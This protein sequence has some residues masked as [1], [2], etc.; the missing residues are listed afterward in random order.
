[1]ILEQQVDRLLA[2]QL[3]PV[4]RRERRLSLLTGWALIGGGA[5]AV[6]ILLRFLEQARAWDARM[7]WLGLC[8]VTAAAGWWWRRRIYGQRDDLTLARRAARL[9]E[10]AD[11]ELRALLLTA[12]AQAPAGPDG[13]LGYLQEELVRQALGKVDAV[14][15]Q[16]AIPKRRLYLRGGAAAAG[17]V[18]LLLCAAGA[19]A[20]ELPT[21]FGDPHGLEVSPGHAEGEQGTN[22][23]VLAR[24]HRRLPAGAML[25][26]RP[27]GKP[28]VRLDMRRTLDDPVWG[29]LT[30]ALAGSRMEYFVEYEGRRSPRYRIA[31]FRAPEVERLDAKVEYPRQ[32]NLPAK[33]VT[34]TRHLSVLEGA[35]VTIT[36]RLATRVEEVRLV[37]VLPGTTD[38]SSNPGE[39]TRLAAASGSGETI[40]WGVVQPADTRRYEVQV[41]DRDGRRNQAPPRLTI[42]VHRNQPA[43]IKLA[44]PGKDVRVSPLEELALEA[45]VEDDVAVLGQGISYRLAG[46]PS[47]E[48]R[49]DAARPGPISLARTSVFLEDLGAKPDQL[50]TYHFWAEDRDGHGK[51]RRAASDMYFAEVRPFEERFREMSSAGGEGEQE[52]GGGPLADQ[53]EKQKQIINATW[54]LERDARDGRP[55][56][57]VGKDA[58]VVAVSQQ[59]LRRE[60][61]EL[62]NKVNDPRVKAGLESAS[63]AMGEAHRELQQAERSESAG[64]VAALG[65]ALE[66]AQRAYASLLR[67]RDRERQVTRGKRGGGEG[68]GE[69]SPELSGLELK[70]KDS[71]YETRKEA[72]A[73]AARPRP[74]RE[75]L[76]RLEELAR[77]QKALSSRLQEAEQSLAR[78]DPAERERRLKSLREEQKELAEELEQLARKLEAAGQNQAARR[79][80]AELEGIAKEA[81][82][83][84]EALARGET[85]KALGA[86]TRA[87]RELERMRKDLAKEVAAGFEDEMRELRDA[88]SKLDQAQQAIGQSLQ[89]NTGAGGVAESPTETRRLAQAARAQKADAEQLL[90]RLQKVSD[91]AEAT[92]PLLSRKLY[93]GLREA[94]LSDIERALDSTAELLER[95]LGEEA[96]ASEERAR[97]GVG[98]LRAQVDD[99]A[100]GVL[101]DPEKALRQ[102][103]AEIDG[104]L[105]EAARQRTEGGPEK[106]QAPGEGQ[107]PGKGQ[108][109]DQGQRQ[110]QGQGQTPGQGQGQG[111]GQGGTTTERWA[112][113]GGRGSA[114]RRSGG[115]G[116]ARRLPA[117]RPAGAARKAPSPAAA[118]AAS[119][120][121]C[122]TSRICWTI[123]AS[124]RAPPRCATAPGPCAQSS[125]ITA[126]VPP[127]PCWRS[128]SGPADRAAPPPG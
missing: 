32:P 93:D 124:A 99:A 28:L 83:T 6:A 41:T 73:K 29:A 9:I 12:V 10:A 58:A 20:P 19:F 36:V 67:V 125:S 50:L 75:A 2:Q 65:R 53:T 80:R 47:Q 101:G 74:E 121:A 102:A 127:P 18:I 45:R 123:P 96:R 100:K 111:Q 23:L 1:M 113:A 55:A 78:S 27:E 5:A 84:S 15:W 31:V 81:A 37:R 33:E 61:D 116:A 43:Q 64:P 77:R 91:Q 24:F 35:R 122:V 51:L 48:I 13:Q 126:S 38:A 26:V 70:Q 106:G 49:L 120:R 117:A 76:S 89:K 110:G 66:A 44:F 85:G 25:V 104:L 21:L 97:R 94:K 114:G 14:R 16:G 79:A 52:G 98:A 107:A 72:S 30:P 87:E 82:A 86:S 59:S 22:V 71:L 109:Q 108:A 8:L 115:R 119:P 40:F 57:E 56:P 54:R 92:A 63:L 39:A 60:T 4:I 17:V 3:E 34:D 11:P 90:D 112:G 103:Q 62:R 105:A 118:F 46:Q 95:N 42:E 128:R 69:N 68:G 88:A 7:G